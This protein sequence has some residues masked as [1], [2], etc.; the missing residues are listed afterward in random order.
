MK[1]VILKIFYLVKLKPKSKKI[2][3][4]NKTSSFILAFN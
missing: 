1:I 3:A 4:N 2:N